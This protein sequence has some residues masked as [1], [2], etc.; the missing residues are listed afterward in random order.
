VFPEYIKTEFERVK[1][2]VYAPLGLDASR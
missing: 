1:D 2:V